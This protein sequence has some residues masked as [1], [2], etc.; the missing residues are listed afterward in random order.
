MGGTFDPVHNGHLQTACEARE[1]LGVEK[2]ILI[3]SREP[4]HRSAPDRSP[5]QRLAML[6]LAIRGMPGLEVD[7]RELHR[8]GPSFTVDTLT[9]LREEVGPD[10]SISMLL[11]LDAFSLLPSWYRW[12]EVLALVNIV[13]LDRPGPDHL[14]V[15]LADLIAERQQQPRDLAG[16]SC[17]SVTRIRTTQLDVSS[18]L[19]REQLAAGHAVDSLLP[20]AV[21]DYI[22][23]Y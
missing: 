23:R 22:C 3:P 14:P 11:G 16:I 21:L 5:E 20:V 19:V 2:V 15:L 1:Q 13:V 12:E 18:T 17:G 10:T 6:R 9:S 8:A 4:P 7:D